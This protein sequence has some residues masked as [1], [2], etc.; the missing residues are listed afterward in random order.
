MTQNPTTENLNLSQF[1]NK[2]LETELKQRREEEKRQILEQRD[3]DAEFWGSKVDTILELVPEHCRTSCS[4]TNA[5][6]D[7]R[8]KRCY[9]LYV[10]QFH[11]DPDRGLSITINKLPEVDDL[12][13]Q[14]R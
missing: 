5:V 6:N 3:I 11:W 14:R 4:D 9:L 13:G 1:S 12:V 2:Q 8:C 10:K 7:T